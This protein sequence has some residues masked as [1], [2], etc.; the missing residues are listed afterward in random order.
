MMRR[1][2]PVSLAIHA[3][4]FSSEG[5]WGVGLGSSSA[6]E[7]GGGGPPTAPPFPGSEDPTETVAVPTTSPPAEASFPGS[8]APTE[9]VTVPTSSSPAEASFPGSEAPTETVTVPTSSSP[10]EA[11]FPGSEDPTETAT[12]PV[13][14]PPAETV[15]LPGSADPTETLAVPTT[16]PA[17]AAREDRTDL[18]LAG[19]PA[20]PLSD[21]TT[22]ALPTTDELA[23][24]HECSN[25]P[26]WNGAPDQRCTQ[27]IQATPAPCENCHRKPSWNGL[28]HEPCVRCAERVDTQHTVRITSSLAAAEQVFVVDGLATIEDLGRLVRDGGVAGSAPPVVQLDFVL[29]EN[30]KV[31][32]SQGGRAVTTTGTEEEFVSAVAG[33]V[34]SKTRRVGYLVKK[35]GLS[36]DQELRLSTIKS[37]A[38]FPEAEAWLRTV[39][40]QLRE[41][42]VAAEEAGL[43]L[44]EF[45][46]ATR[47][48][49]SSTKTVN[50]DLVAFLLGKFVFYLPPMPR[51][52]QNTEDLRVLLRTGELMIPSWFL[53]RNAAGLDGHVRAA[54][55]ALQGLSVL[56]AGDEESS[57]SSSRSPAAITITEKS[58][59]TIT[60]DDLTGV[61]RGSDGGRSG[62]VRAGREGAPIAT[63]AAPVVAAGGCATQWSWRLSKPILAE[64]SGPTGMQEWKRAARAAVQDLVVLIRG[65]GGGGAAGRYYREALAEQ[66]ADLVSGM[67]QQA[68][69]GGAD[70]HV[71]D[72]IYYL[73]AGVF[74]FLSETTDYT[75][76]MPDSLAELLRRR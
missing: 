66:L 16:S 55:A 41:G 21:E 32:S 14:S 42:G 19:Y 31:G 75:W 29:G 20:Q 74:N 57:V 44:A 22:A 61:G 25:R 64:G 73:G 24:C 39:R 47:R 45:C 17:A 58:P 59:A 54:R 69:D 72:W 62:V 7:I 9:T 26:S 5:V 53:G 23:L 68:R 48:S 4:L 43:R 12:V 46:T 38:P 3:L 10:A 6:A 56:I 28:P 71:V 36:A 40:D 70:E 37:V 52:G 63:A 76:R 67:A 33:R 60:E 15:F 50:R 27:C 30:A 11:S 51:H 8:E 18:V 1:F 34:L 13:T 2:H 35:L 65:E 49:F